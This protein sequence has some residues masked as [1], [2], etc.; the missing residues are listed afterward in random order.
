[1][2]GWFSLTPACVKSPA[3]T[4]PVVISGHSLGEGHFCLNISMICLQSG[5]Q[6]PFL[7]CTISHLRHKHCKVELQLRPLPE[8][9][10][11]Q[12]TQWM[13]RQCA[14]MMDGSYPDV[15]GWVSS[16]TP[17]FQTIC[18]IHHFSFLWYC[19]H[20][21]PK[22]RGHII[23]DLWQAA[24]HSPLLLWLEA[25]WSHSSPLGT[26]LGSQPPPSKSLNDPRHLRKWTAIQNNVS[27][28]DGELLYNGYKVSDWDDEKDPEMD[29]GGGFR[30]LWMLL[31][32]LNHT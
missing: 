15:G 6:T 26:R 24:L 9:L 13:L 29:G 3:H 8:D 19:S 12:P 10:E 32:P 31:K 2:G 30:T 28:G 22:H 4:S 18:N 25:T 11:T 27:W 20:L 23:L 21:I 17:V 14:L 7:T 5:M 16:S 1:M